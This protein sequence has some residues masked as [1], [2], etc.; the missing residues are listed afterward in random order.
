M[1]SPH[2]GSPHMGGSHMSSSQSHMQNG[3][4]IRLPHAPEIPTLTRTKPRSNTTGGLHTHPSHH[5]GHHGHGHPYHAHPQQMY[6]SPPAHHG[7]HLHHSTSNSSLHSLH[8][9]SQSTHSPALAPSALSLDPNSSSSTNG[10]GGGGHELYRRGSLPDFH[11]PGMGALGPQAGAG[12][13]GGEWDDNG[14]SVKEEPRAV[15]V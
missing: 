3:N 1:G 2:L 15:L 14:V 5:S 12:A 6:Y 7:G 11:N 13:G 9:Q 4:G 8:S 10:A